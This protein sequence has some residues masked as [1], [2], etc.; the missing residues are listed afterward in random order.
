MTEKVTTSGGCRYGLDREDGPGGAM[1][2]RNAE[3]GGYW[4]SLW[5]VECGGNR[6][7]K[8]AHGAL[9]AATG[10]PLVTTNRNGRWNVMVGL[11]EPGEVFLT[12]TMAAFSGESDPWAQLRSFD[13][14]RSARIVPA[15]ASAGSV[16][17]MTS[18]QRAMA[19]SP[20]RRTATMGPS[21]M[22][23]TS[24]S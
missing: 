1:R 17:P 5:P 6:R 7:Q 20:S 21:V 10:H 8:A 22:K 4:P 2:D 11:R 18:R 3:R 19:P 12:G 24:E 13:V 14:P 23:A 15:A 16:A 9:D